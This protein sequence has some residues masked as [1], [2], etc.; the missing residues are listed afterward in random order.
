MLGGMWRTRLFPPLLLG[1]AAILLFAGCTG[2]GASGRTPSPDPNGNS[3]PQSN[4]TGNAN[5]GGPAT[6]D[7]FA[8]WS[9]GTQLR[10]ANIFQ[11][12]V[13]P[14]VDGPDFL[15]PGPLGPP[16]T[17]AD[18]DRLAALGANCVN[19]S[20]TGLFTQAEPYEP[21]PDVEANLDA[22]LDMIQQADMFAVIS[23]RSGPG[24]GEFALFPFEGLPTEL[25]D[26][27]V[28][29]NA[30][31]QDGWVAM[32]RYA[33]E[34]YGNR[35]IVVGYDLM[36]EPN[37]PA[38]ILNI[39]DPA[40]FYPVNADLLVDWNQLHPRLTAAIREADTETPII[41]GANNFS[42]VIWLPFLRLSDDDR[43]VYAVHDYEPFNYTHQAPPNLTLTYPGLFDADGD[44]TPDSVDR[45]WIES[46]LAPVQSFMQSNGVPI[47]ANEF[48][49]QRW[50]PGA[51]AYITDRMDVWEQLGVHHA[52]WLWTASHPPLAE[53]DAFNFRH[54]PDPD[55]HA[56]VPQSELLDAIRTNWQRNAIRP[57]LLSPPR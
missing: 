11:R 34:R 44:G 56:D 1:C 57:S 25:V 24:R 33:A 20:H 14:D 50:E 10:G 22:L 30:L 7:K 39:F 27:S 36:V 16:Y 2:G 43:T 31:A 5:G 42:S 6:T 38:A 4:S 41:V 37:A 17:Q 55:N 12:R 23:F 21:D 9:G 52:N 53:D 46:F 48:G 32:W 40:E 45:A 49:V 26:Q 28:W 51:A 15:G 54:G 18:F 8:L 47:V 13:Y 29:R 35:V 19:I 3:N